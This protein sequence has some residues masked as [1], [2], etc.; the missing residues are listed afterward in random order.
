[1]LEF[2]GGRDGAQN[3][4]SSSIFLALFRLDF[5]HFGVVIKGLE[6]SLYFLSMDCRGK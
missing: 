5:F 1:M 2:Q 4:S 3:S 6:L